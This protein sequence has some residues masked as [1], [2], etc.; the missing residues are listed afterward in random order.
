LKS[1]E[2]IK[3]KSK[4]WT[5]QDPTILRQKIHCP[6]ETTKVIWERNGEWGKMATHGNLSEDYI[7]EKI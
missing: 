6:I 2:R 5:L 1:T 3:R 4:A 7:S